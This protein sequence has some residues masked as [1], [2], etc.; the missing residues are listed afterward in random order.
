MRR[1]R[2]GRIG[3]RGRLFRSRAAAELT[4]ELDGGAHGGEGGD[5]QDAQVVKVGDAFVLVFLEQGLEHGAGLGAVF[6]EDV[7]L[8][9]VVG[10]LAPGE[11][12]LIEGDVADEVKGIE[13]FTDLLGQRTSRTRPSSSRSSMMACLRSVAR[14]SSEEV[15]EVANRLLEGL[16]G[17]VAQGLGDELAVFI[18]VF[19]ALGDDGVGT[20]ST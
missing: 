14:H 13:V 6:G 5:L 11:R 4:D 7:A 3:V 2:R 10:A 17:E 12:R 15:V 20:P 18:E 1:K 16:A 9:D 19:D 8:A